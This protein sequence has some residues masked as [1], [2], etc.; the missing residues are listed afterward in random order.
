MVDGGGAHLDDLSVGLGG[1]TCEFGQNN[2]GLHDLGDVWHAGHNKKVTTLVEVDEWSGMGVG[3]YRRQRSAGVVAP[4][5][6]ADGRGTTCL[7]GRSGMLRGRAARW[8]GE[9]ME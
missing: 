5:E 8:R 3:R 7:F 9:A 6:E 1:F 2:Q 4:C